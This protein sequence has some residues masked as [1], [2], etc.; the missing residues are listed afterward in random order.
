MPIALTVA[1][2]VDA[3]QEQAAHQSKKASKD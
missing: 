2:T 1:V 3:G